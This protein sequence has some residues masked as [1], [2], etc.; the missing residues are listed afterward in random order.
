MIKAVIFDLDHTLF[1]RYK[2][3]RAIVKPLRALLPIDPTLSDD[4]VGDIMVNADK[5][6]I[7]HGWDRVREH[8]VNETKLKA[9]KK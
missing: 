7:Y 5:M 1:D 3:L 2:T 8:I 4:E 6:C 9:L